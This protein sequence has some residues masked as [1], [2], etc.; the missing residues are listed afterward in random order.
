MTRR[1]A[2]SSLHLR[3]CYFEDG[4]RFLFA[5]LIVAAMT[6]CRVERD[7]ESGDRRLAA[8]HLEVT[9][10]EPFSYV[11]SVRELSDGTILVADPISQV[12]LRIDLDAG[13]TDTLGRQGAGPQEYQE[14]DQV[15]PLPA[16]STLLVDLGNGRLTVIDPEGNFVGW[17]PMTTNSESAPMGV[18]TVHPRFLDAAGNVYV[19]GPYD[20][21]GPPDSTV[22]HRI[23]RV[24][25]QKVP[26]RRPGTRSMSPDREAPRAP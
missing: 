20:P 15:F 2:S 5:L 26:S 17:T 19:T 22:I 3:S 23:D 11:S 10:P 1:I 8:L 24:S 4:L 18:R 13:T 16:D 25:G 12:L 7:T 21:E 6:S 9:Y 14:P